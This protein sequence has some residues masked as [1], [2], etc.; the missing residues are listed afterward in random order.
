MSK[1]EGNFS[2]LTLPSMTPKVFMSHSINL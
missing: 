2:L 1:T